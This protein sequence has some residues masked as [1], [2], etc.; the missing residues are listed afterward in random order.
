MAFITA[1][2]ILTQAPNNIKTHKSNYNL[3]ID[4]KF[5]TISFKS[6]V[7]IKG[8]TFIT[9]ENLAYFD[10]IKKYSKI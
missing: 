5:S 8:K 2:V 10:K 7:I 4:I 3:R 6:I 1:L 9:I